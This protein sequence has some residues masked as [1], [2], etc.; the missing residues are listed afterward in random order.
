MGRPLYWS[1]DMRRYETKV[2]KA[3]WLRRDGTTTT[4]TI[5]ATVGSKLMR[6]VRDTLLRV[7]GPVE[8]KVK[9]VERSSPPIMMGLATNNPFPVGEQ[10]AL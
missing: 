5:P 3:T 2:D 6:V 10:T 7:A 4:I 1:K 8:T 9:V